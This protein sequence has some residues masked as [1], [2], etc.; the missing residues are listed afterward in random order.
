MN[1]KHLMSYFE[2]AQYSDLIVNLSIIAKEK[3]MLTLLRLAG[4]GDFIQDYCNSCQDYC[5]KEE[6]FGSSPNIPKTT[7]NLE[8]RS[9]GILEEQE[10]SSAGELLQH[11]LNRILAK[12]DQDDQ[13]S[14]VWGDSA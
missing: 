12:E 2:M 1:V 9:R 4:G 7:G 13:I 11:Q 5:N 3:I 6:K 8:S 14:R 10:A